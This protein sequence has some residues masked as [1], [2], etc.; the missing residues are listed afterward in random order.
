MLP[1]RI[2]YIYAYLVPKSFLTRQHIL[3]I[4]LHLS[5]WKARLAMFACDIY[6]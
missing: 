6:L 4:Y 3:P 2:K 5:L 1:S